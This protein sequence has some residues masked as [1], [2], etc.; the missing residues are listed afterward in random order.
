M[1]TSSRFLAASALALAVSASAVARA[2]SS[3]QDSAVAQSLYDEARKLAG[4]NDF[5]TAC[6]KLE[7]SQRLDPTPVTQFWLA[8][9]Y[10]HVGRTASAWAAFLDL[11]A[12]EHKTGGP[13]S[14]EREKL[15]RDRASAL[16]PKLTQ[17][18]IDVP[19][20]VRV[21][22]LVVKRDGEA[23][24]D[25]QWGTPVAVDPGN[26]KLDASAPGKQPWTQT[27]DVEGEGQTIRVQVDPLVDAPAPP[28]VAA[29]GASPRVDQS[30]P[31]STSASS[32]WKTVGLV[33]AGVGVVGLGVGTVFGVM[34]LGKNS[35]ANSGHCGGAL[36]G[37]NQCDAT[38][39]SDRSTAV[40]D[41]NVSTV[42]IIAGG[43]LA[44]GGVALWL[45]APSSHVQAAP[46]VGAGAGGIVVRGDF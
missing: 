38:G 2:Q 41:G 31:P 14:E 35:D 7:E 10:E 25:G 23:V 13:K 39:V 18:T 33:A 5:A 46:A 20:A 19:A 15:A 12:V 45:L 17:L 11:A 43:V 21:D 36:G 4:S 28:P 44:A 26:H 16:A 1:K 27:L 37:P 3:A 8:D 22:G 34:A 42:F 30:L 9:C 24:R 32:P 40:S 6:P 29:S